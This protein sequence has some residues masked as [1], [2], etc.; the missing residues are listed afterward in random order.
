MWLAVSQYASG[1]VSHWQLGGYAQFVAGGT[2]SKPKW[3]GFHWVAMRPHMGLAVSQ[4]VSMLNPLDGIRAL[5]GDVGH[6]VQGGYAR[7]EAGT[8]GP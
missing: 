1:D 2:A 3:R 7:Y 8:G 6:W 5:R 4:S